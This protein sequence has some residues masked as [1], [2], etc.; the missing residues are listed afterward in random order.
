MGAEGLGAVT[1]RKRM[2]SIDYPDLI[3]LLITGGGPDRVPLSDPRTGGGPDRIPLSDPLIAT[4]GKIGEEQAMAVALRELRATTRTEGLRLD[5][6][7]M[8]PPVKRM[9]IL[10][11]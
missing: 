11:L 2:L 3:P 8:D 6:V 5:I 1:A 4:I 10:V 7:R 9:A